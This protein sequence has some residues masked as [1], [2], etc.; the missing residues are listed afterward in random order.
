[1]ISDV[2]QV[3]G[4][5]EDTSVALIV[6]NGSEQFCQ[7][8][9]RF[10]ADLR[11]SKATVPP[12]VILAGDS[13]EGFAISSLRAGAVEYLREPIEL[14]TLAQ[15]I[16]RF[17]PECTT[18]PKETALT[19][20]EVLVGNSPV[21]QALRTQIRLV[22]A[23]DCNVLITGETGTGKE[24]VA[25]LIHRNSRR[26]KNPL[27]CFNCAA[28]PDTLLE[29]E[30]FGYERGAFTGAAA[31]NQGK[32]MAANRGSVF[33]DEIGD[34]SPLAQA[35]VLRAIETKEV[36]RLGATRKH[37]TDIRIL[38]AT[39]HNLDELAS[40]N[41]FRRDLYFRLNVGRI[42]LPP[43]RER[44]VDIA[45]LVDCMIVDLNKRLGRRVEGATSAIVRR[46]AQYDWPGNVRE[47][48]NVI[49]RVFIMRESGR[50][51]EDDLSFVLPERKPPAASSLDEEIH[52]LRKA[53]AT[54]N[55]NK[56]K[57]AETLNCSRMTLYRKLA[58]CGL[59]K[60][61]AAGI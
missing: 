50:I 7:P 58:K 26:N 36:Q 53:L 28:I 11:S 17:V 37:E 46:L 18:Q 43:L 14:A 44:K 35:K 59:S 5:L 22:A 48:K 20:G 31:A 27:V 60:Q 30:L 21:L 61:D 40:A 32:L 2:A 52:S 45:G 55:G 33:F 49:E 13:S 47:L 23:S 54:C 57:A 15:C 39:H 38:A 56:S 12:L 6:L 42:Y 25:Q 9:F 10:L 41:T 4:A 1:M 3:T 29:S 34:M 51:S 8:F 19:G 24:L 16:S